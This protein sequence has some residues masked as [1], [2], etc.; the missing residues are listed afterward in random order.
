[1][2]AQSKTE[3]KILENSH[4]QKCCH[5]T[6]RESSL[7][8]SNLCH[9]TTV[10]QLSHRQSLQIDVNRGKMSGISPC[11]EANKLACHSFLDT[12]RS[13]ETFGHVTKTLLLTKEQGTQLPAY[14]NSSQPQHENKQKV[15]THEDSHTEHPVLN[16]RK[17]LDFINELSLFY[18][19]TEKNM[20]FMM[21]MIKQLC[22]C[23]NLIS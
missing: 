23:C 2:L 22:I 7:R 6:L 20:C 16:F 19:T 10:A 3:I 12:G 14:T 11:L 13:R 5:G 21:L 17:K 8:F 18:L 15:D 9:F 4:F 1:M